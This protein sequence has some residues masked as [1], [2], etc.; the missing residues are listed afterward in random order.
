MKIKIFLKAKRKNIK[1]QFIYRGGWE[2][3][4]NNIKDVVKFLN[5]MVTVLPQDLHWIICVD[6]K[7]SEHHTTAYCYN[8]REY[9]Y[10]TS[11][12]EQLYRLL[13]KEY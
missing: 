7:F 1:P 9:Y 3:E 5:G 2:R 8:I 10:F 6:M 4:V 13:D 11:G 12:F